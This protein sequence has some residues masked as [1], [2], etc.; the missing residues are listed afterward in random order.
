M[1]GRA[2]LGLLI[3][4]GSPI[5]PGVDPGS[6]FVYSVDDNLALKLIFP[7]ELRYFCVSIIPITLPSSL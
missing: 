2:G 5:I 4:G 7:V 1:N 6:F 3:V